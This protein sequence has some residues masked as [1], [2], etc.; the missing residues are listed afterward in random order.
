M[1]S[2][3]HMSW[4]KTQK[5]QS[6]LLA[7]GGGVLLFV[8]LFFASMPRLIPIAYVLMFGGIIIFSK[9]MQGIGKFMRDKR[10]DDLIDA[11]LANLSDRY[12]TIHYATV[13]KRTIEHMV[14]HPGGMLVLAAREVDGKV[15]QRHK[16]WKRGGGFFS[17]F[18]RFSG[19]Q[20]TNPSY[21]LERDLAALDA[22]L[23]EHMVSVDTLGAV[24][25]LH[26]KVI[27]DIQDP[28]YPVLMYDEVGMFLHDLKP[29][30]TFTDD[31]RRTII[32]LFSQ[33]A[34]EAEV[35][36]KIQPS[37]RP[38]PKVRARSATKPA[39]ADASRDR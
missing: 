34:E 27:L 7:I 32:D 31:E 16:S 30:P 2:I 28:D 12:V 10:N 9:G 4:V 6:K 20:L 18:L 15:I 11:R 36:K 8:S 3:R 37:R 35:E 22:A 21:D 25:F 1:R 5:R 23:A 13:G 19:P 17:K 26:P 24:L 33:G 38:R 29:D 14:V 39:S